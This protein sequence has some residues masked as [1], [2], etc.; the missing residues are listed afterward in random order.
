MTAAVGPR[1]HLSAGGLEFASDLGPREALL[2]ETPAGLGQILTARPI[3]KKRHNGLR[4]FRRLVRLKEVLTGS[5]RKALSPHGRRDDRLAHGHRFED[6]E[7]RPA[8]TRRGTI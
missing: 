6:L 5:K 1:G 8:P 2:D 4:E 3:A 7:T